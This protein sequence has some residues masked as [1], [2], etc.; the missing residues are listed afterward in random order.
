M[1]A[2]GART[3]HLADACGL[4]AARARAR[5]AS[6]AAAAEEQVEH[7]AGGAL[8]R[9]VKIVCPS[10]HPVAASLRT[11]AGAAADLVTD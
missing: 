7:G 8:L 5:G 11:A 4:Y 10:A 6:A 3:H 1:L 9:H 2:S